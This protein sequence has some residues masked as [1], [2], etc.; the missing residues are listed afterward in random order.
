MKQ[1]YTKTTIYH[2]SMTPRG[3]LLFD[4]CT[5]HLGLKRCT[6]HTRNWETQEDIFKSVWIPV[7][8]HFYGNP[9]KDLMP[10]KSLVIDNKPTVI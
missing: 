3:V 10:I 6:G 9:I 1:G 8:L 7:L 2:N 5:T 4:T